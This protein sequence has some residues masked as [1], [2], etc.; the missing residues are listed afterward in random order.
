MVWLLIIV[1]FPGIVYTQVKINFAKDKSITS[2]KAAA[3]ASFTLSSVSRNQI[4]FLY[5][6]LNQFQISSWPCNISMLE[7][8]NWQ[9]QILESNE[10]PPCD[11]PRGFVQRRKILIG[12]SRPPQSELNHQT[13]RALQSEN[14]FKTISVCI[15]KI[16]SNTYCE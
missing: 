2:E 5:K 9:C 10:D 1:S 8:S 14:Q 12:A 6:N 16:I 3:L 11:D 15:S 4:I 13:R 7:Q